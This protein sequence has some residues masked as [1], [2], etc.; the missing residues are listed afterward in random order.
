MF[1]TAAMA[2]FGSPSEAGNV[3]ALIVKLKFSAN[4]AI[5]AGIGVAAAELFVGGLVISLPERRFPLWMV[6]VMLGAFT[7]VILILMSDT[8]APGCGCFG[9]I[10]HGR[11]DLPWGLARN[12]AAIVLTAI[13][14]RASR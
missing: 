1:I 10:V 9:R 2:E 11:K 13:L 12:I 5:M 7:L 6:L 4:Q 8:T 14:L 3:V